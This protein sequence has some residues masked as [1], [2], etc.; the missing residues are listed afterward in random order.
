MTPKRKQRLILVGL[1]LAGVGTAVTF[2][3]TAF[4]DNIMLFHSPSD[5]VAGN[6]QQGT[7]FRIGGMVVEDSVQ[8]SNED[9]AVRF[10]LTDHAQTVPVSFTGILPDLFQE[11]QGIVAL[12][13][14]DDS[15][16]FTASEV[17]AKHDENY[18]PPEVAEALEK[19]GKM[20]GTEAKFDNVTTVVD[21]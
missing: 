12:G 15:G 20:P 13:A 10:E 19:A 6:V 17:L 18:M 16:T 7:A 9:L 8:R 21:P 5:V 1:M 14:I 3:I 4:K 11:G 2:G